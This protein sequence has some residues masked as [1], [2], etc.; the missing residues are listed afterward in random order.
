[1]DVADANLALWE[2]DK[3]RYLRRAHDIIPSAGA[4]VT[5]ND[6]SRCFLV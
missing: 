1:V 3:E 2:N 6:R 5:A 4:E